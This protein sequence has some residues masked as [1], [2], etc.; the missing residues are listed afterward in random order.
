M[1]RFETILFVG[2][3]YG[4]ESSDSDPDLCGHECV[5]GH[6][7]EG[8][9]RLSAGLFGSDC[10]IETKSST[11]ICACDKMDFNVFGARIAPE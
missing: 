2:C 1:M 7:K 11:E 4:C 8:V 9:E 10:S 3:D 5:Q 6:D